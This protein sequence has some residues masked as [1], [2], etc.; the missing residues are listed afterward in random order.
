MK[1]WQVYVRGMLMGAADV[2]PGISGGTIAFITG[3]YERLIH[4]LCSFNTSLWPTWRQQGWRGVFQQVD[5][6]FLLALLGGVLTSIAL[7]AHLISWLLHHYPLPLYG[8]IFGLVAGSGLIILRE[9][10]RLNLV[11]LLLVLLGVFIAAHLS[12]LLPNLSTLSLPVFFFSGMA[13]ICALLLPGISGSF[14]LLVLGMYAPVLNAIKNLQLDILLVF[15]L[16]AGT[17]L[18]VFSHLLNWLLNHLRAPTFAL[19]LGFVLGSLKQLWPWQQLISYR[20]SSQGQLLPL[21]TQVLLPNRFSE[22]T[23]QAAYPITVSLLMLLG[24][25]LVVYLSSKNRPS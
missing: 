16:G 17:G 7:F 12:Q 6:G 18:L 21:E 8:L 5:A 19:L 14:I 22:L 13:A 9:A 24:F 2:M 1:A 20:I 10:G 23:N 25:A 3:V 15:A 11:Q 4:S